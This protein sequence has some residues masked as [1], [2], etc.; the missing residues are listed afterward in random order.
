MNCV[1][2]KTSIFHIHSFILLL[3]L[4][5]C[6]FR[7]K[8]LRRRVL[9]FS[10]TVMRLIILTGANIAVHMNVTE[11]SPGSIS[12]TRSRKEKAGSTIMF[13]DRRRHHVRSRTQHHHKQHVLWRARK[14][15]GR[16]LYAC[17]YIDARR[18][19]KMN[20]HYTKIKF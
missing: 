2:Q 7:Q 14:C 13:L 1:W 17:R 19:G 20:V 5:L 8:A 11:F 18:G 15:R 6:R 3:I 10:S 12:K 9:V 4:S 16:Q